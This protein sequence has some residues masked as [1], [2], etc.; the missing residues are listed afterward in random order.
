MKIVADGV[1]SRL[2]NIITGSTDHVAKKTGLTCYRIAVSIEDAEKAL[3]DGSLPH[4]WDPSTCRN[5]TS[6]TM[7]ADGTSRMVVA[8]PLRRE[9]YFNLSCIVQTSD[10]SKPTTDSWNADGDQAKLLETFRDF[11]EPLRKV[12]R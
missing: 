8:Y 3:G 10:S 5:R 1:H 11:N 2:R 9:T 7:A 4:W 6:L 12:L